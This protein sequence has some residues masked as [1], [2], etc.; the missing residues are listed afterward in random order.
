MLK[1]MQLKEAGGHIHSPKIES[2]L[3]GMDVVNTI[4]LTEIPE[5]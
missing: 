1:N 2:Y 3:R 4:T 5:V